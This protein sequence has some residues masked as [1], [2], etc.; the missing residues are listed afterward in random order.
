MADDIM[1]RCP[2]CSAINRVP[3]AEIGPGQKAICGRCKAALPVA[4]KPA[5]VSD[6]TFAAHAAWW[7]RRSISSPSSSAAASGSP[8]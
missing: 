3:T 2:S 5:V 6:A 7:R 8:R 1:V 4:T